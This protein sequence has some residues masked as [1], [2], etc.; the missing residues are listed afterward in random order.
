MATVR[1][2]DGAP[3]VTVSAAADTNAL[4]ALR[5][6]YRGRADAVREAP[7]CIVEIHE[8]IALDPRALLWIPDFE[9]CLAWAFFDMRRA[10][11]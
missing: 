10:S 11:S 2:P 3:L 5:R 1:R 8:T 9:R 6:L 4:Y 7:A